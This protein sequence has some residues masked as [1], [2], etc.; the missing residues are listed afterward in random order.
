MAERLLAHA[1]DNPELI[2]RSSAGL[3]ATRAA[4]PFPALALLSDPTLDAQQY[5]EELV[6]LAAASAQEA[7][8]VADH[9]RAVRTKARRGML[10]FA[11]LGALGVLAGAAGLA[12]RGGADTKLEEVQSQ[13]TSL[14]DQQRQLEDQLA[15]AT[16]QAREARPTVTPATVTVTPA[17]VPPS[18]ATPRFVPVQPVVRS[19]QAWPDSRPPAR[20]WSATQPRQTVVVPR[21][22]ADL[23]RNF[24]NIFR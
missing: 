13:V 21:F 20:H 5:L 16:E 22:F 19:S 1:M 4:P 23:E 6:S 10:V 17:V 24:R 2:S 9:A 8:E 11:S 14:R 12:A 15:R 18:I 3:L 7:A